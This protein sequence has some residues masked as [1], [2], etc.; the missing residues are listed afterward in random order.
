MNKNILI[1]IGIAVLIISGYFL[2]RMVKGND[3]SDTEVTP[4]PTPTP[5]YQTVD[6]SVQADVAMQPNGKYVDISVT[7]LDGKFEMLEYELSYDTDKGPKGVIGKITLTAGQDEAE[8]EERL[9]TCSTGGKCTDHTG[10]ENF[11]LVI[12]FHT[13]DGEIFILEKEFEEV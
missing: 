1:G 8:R 6:E 4:T 2:F 7:G 12:K 10:V 13:E 3:G 11:K 5:S 9:G